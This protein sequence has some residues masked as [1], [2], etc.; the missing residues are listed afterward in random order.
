MTKQHLEEIFSHTLK[1]NGYFYL[2]LQVNPLAHTCMPADY[3]ILTQEFSYLIECK[4]CKN[5][6]FDFN[7][8]TQESE[9]IK[10][11]N[12]GD[13]FNAGILLC[14]WKGTKKKSKYF[15]I[16]IDTYENVK[17]AIGK[18]SISLKD[19]EYYFNNSTVTFLNNNCLSI[20]TKIR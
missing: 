8:L 3:I 15:L 12:L 6:R 4:E 2:K 19:A 20:N 17:N 16:S 18:K 1:E 7:R 9:L 10:F 13:R 5:D 14:F 11:E